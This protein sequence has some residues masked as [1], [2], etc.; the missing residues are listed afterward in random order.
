V[1]S[2]ILCTTPG[3]T[4]CSIPEYSPSVFSRIRTVSTPLYG[5]L[6]PAMER[7]GRTFAK[8][9]KVLRRVRLRETWPFPIGVANGPFR[10]IVFF[11]T[12]KAVSRGHNGGRQCTGVDCV[13]W[14]CCFS[15]FENWCYIHWFPYNRSLHQPL[16]PRNTL[17][18]LKMAS[19]LSAI[20]GPIPS[21][22]IIVTVY[23]P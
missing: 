12:G 7:Q 6:Y 17:A 13:V 22:G 4:T 1:I 9:E 15:V 19:T 5:V 2:L 23:I 14:D 11:L 16:L 3:I 21:P 20:S 8:R 18:A 10:A